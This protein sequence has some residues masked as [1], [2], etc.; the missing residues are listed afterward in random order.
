MR[1]PNLQT[2]TP[3]ITNGEIILIGEMSGVSGIEVYEG[4][5]IFPPAV[6]IDRISVMGGIQKELFDMELWEV[7][8][9][10]EEGMEERKHIVPGSPLQKRENGKITVGI[11]SHIYVE[12][13]AK[14]ITFL[15]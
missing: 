6:I 1:K 15:V 7:C 11:G 8:F 10:S 5:D 2:G 12:V 13:V 9:H 14:E 4:R 3:F